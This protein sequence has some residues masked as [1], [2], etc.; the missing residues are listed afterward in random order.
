MITIE[1]IE[2]KLGTQDGWKVEEFKRGEQYKVVPSLA[3]RFIRM[4]VAKLVEAEQ[5][6]GAAS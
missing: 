5:A 4:G 2:T 1:M 6:E 3:C